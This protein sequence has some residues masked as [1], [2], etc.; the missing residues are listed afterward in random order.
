MIIETIVDYFRLPRC[1]HVMQM[2]KTVEPRFPGHQHSLEHMETTDC[3]RC[4]ETVSTNGM[5]CVKC[6][7]K[8]T[9]PGVKLL[10]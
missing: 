5:F 7:I 4:P 8:R 3:Y 6:S 1:V 9:C 2:N 10:W